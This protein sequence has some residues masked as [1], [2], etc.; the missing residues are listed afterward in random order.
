[1]K[2]ICLNFSNSKKLRFVVVVFGTI[3]GSLVVQFLFAAG[4]VLD[5]AIEW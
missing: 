1:M 2:E 4:L 5:W 3:S